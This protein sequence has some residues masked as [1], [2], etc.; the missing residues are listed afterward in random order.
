MSP[1][2][3]ARIVFDYLRATEPPQPCDLALGLGSFDLRVAR[4]CAQLF[5]SGL[6]REVLFS[7]DRGRATLDLEPPEASA[8]RHEALALGV[9]PDRV[10]TEIRSKN[11]WENVVFSR[12][13]IGSTAALRETRMIA[14]V[15]S[16]CFQ[17]RAWLTCLRQFHGVRFL[18]HPPE[19]SLEVE[20][21]L[22]LD[23][24]ERLVDWMKG[25]IERIPQYQASGHIASAPLPATIDR[26]ISL[27][28]QLD[29]PCPGNPSSDPV[30]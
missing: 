28:D 8:F 27:L 13:L 4:T 29:S 11:M 1:R 17:R 10:F 23:K 24:G 22:F 16:P 14:L 25:E 12:D 3:A 30:A 15:A 6:V 21:R 20:Q 7:G 9:P 2:E 19:S 26:M 5:R 18:N